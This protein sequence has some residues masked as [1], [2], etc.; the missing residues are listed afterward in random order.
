MKSPIVNDCLKVNIDG[1]TEPQLV[2]IFFCRS[3]F[4]NFIISLLVTQKMAESKKQ[5]MN[6]IISLLVIL[7]Y[8][9]YCH[10]NEKKCHQYTRSCVVASVVYLK[11][12]YITH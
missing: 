10:P 12:V 9:H 8:V 7:Q 3:P 4:K 5:E 1:P 11:K 6:R 2:P